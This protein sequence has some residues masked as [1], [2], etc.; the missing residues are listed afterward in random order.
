[1]GISVNKNRALVTDLMEQ[2]KRADPEDNSEQIR[3]M[4][5]LVSE[6]L[7][8]DMSFAEQNGARKK[9][10]KEAIMKPEFRHQGFFMRALMP[11]IDTA[12]NKLFSRTAI[13][14]KLGICTDP[15]QREAL[16][17]QCFRCDSDMKDDGRCCV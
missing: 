4:E 5:K 17:K 11:S 2:V 14:S 10:T 15:E 9:M 13:I 7:D 3:T 1:M 16:E 12:M 8:S 6:L